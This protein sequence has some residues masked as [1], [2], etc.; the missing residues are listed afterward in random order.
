MNARIMN[1]FSAAA[2]R[3]GHSMLS[4]TLLRLDE[5]GR[6]ID[7][8]HLALREAFFAPNLIRQ[9]GIDP[10]LRG[11]SQQ[12]AQEV[13]SYVIDDVRNFL[14]GN[15]G[16]GGFDL[17]SLNIQRGRDHGLPSY[18]DARRELGL[19]PA[20]DF[21]DISSDT[22]T[23]RRLQLAYA[24]VEHVDLWV[25]GMAEDNYR[26][27][28]LGELFHTIV[29]QQFEALRAGDRFWYTNVLS[30]EDQE[31]VEALRLADIIRLNT[32]IGRE[33]Q[34]DVFTIRGTR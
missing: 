19:T 32:S 8:G 28:M 25:G 29:R 20:R 33:I 1:E 3:L 21:R 24:D 5:R 4:P 27:S 23:A 7:A 14:F 30:R 26:S 12:L 13:D 9:H 34:D 17:V 6:P 11:L 10:L 2:F 18:N 16:T 22:E 31:R 15:P